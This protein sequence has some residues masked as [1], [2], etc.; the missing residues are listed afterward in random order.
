MQDEIAV[1]SEPQ[2]FT[3][4][5]LTMSDLNW[6]VQWMRDMG[7]LRKNDLPKITIWLD[8]KECQ[9][10]FRLFVGRNETARIVLE[11]VS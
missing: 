11:S 8:G 7:H 9:L 10:K 3:T 4:E 5:P 1:P 6:Q 2:Y